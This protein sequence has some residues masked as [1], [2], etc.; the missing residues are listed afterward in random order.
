MHELSI[1]VGIVEAV[2]EEA[3]K[4]GSARVEIVFVRLGRLSGIVKEALLSSYD[5]ACQGTSLEGSRLDIE[6]I[7][8]VIYCTDCAAQHSLRSLQCFYCPVCGSQSTEI[9]HGRELEIRALEVVS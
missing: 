7:P 3:A 1:A 5:L 6:E 2:E 4:Q 9:R 8:V